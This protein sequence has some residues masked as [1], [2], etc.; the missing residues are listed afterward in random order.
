MVQVVHDFVEVWAAR[1]CGGSLGGRPQ[2]GS[3]ERWLHGLVGIAFLALAGTALAKPPVGFSPPGLQSHGPFSLGMTFGPTNSHARVGVSPACD[4]PEV[5]AAKAAID[6]DCPCAGTPGDAD[7]MGVPTVVPWKNHG[8]YVSC[9]ARAR[10][11]EARNSGVSMRCLVKVVPCAAQSNCGKTDDISCI[12]VT[13]GVC[14]GDPLPGDLS[15][16]GACE[17]DTT[18]LC[19]TDADC[20]QSSC[21]VMNET[22][23]FAA[24]GEPAVGTCCSQ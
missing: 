6:A 18:V 11:A 15:Q 3:N 19:D 17:N 5:T 14:V 4:A 21:A 7:S 12:T 9:I 22:D 13:P 8:E 20:S 24:D 10:S 1:L 23:C 16:E 2:M